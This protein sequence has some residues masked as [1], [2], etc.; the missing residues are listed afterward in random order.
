MA[1]ELKI[2][3]L[4]LEDDQIL[5]EILAMPGYKPW[6]PSQRGQKWVPQK[7]TIKPIEHFGATP[8]KVKK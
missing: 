6:N 7:V 3:K 8:P 2:S 5:P 4:S 1:S